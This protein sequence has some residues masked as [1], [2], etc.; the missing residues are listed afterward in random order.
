LVAEFSHKEA[1]KAQKKS[2]ETRFELLCFFV[3]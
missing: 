3:A 1:K 2:A